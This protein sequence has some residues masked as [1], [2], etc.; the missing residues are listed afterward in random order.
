M[1]PR[2][3]PLWWPRH[4]PNLLLT[5]VPRRSSR[6]A[7][8]RSLQTFPD[9]PLLALWTRARHLGSIARLR[10][11]PDHVT[12][13]LAARWADAFEPL[14]PELYWTDGA[15]DALDRAAPY[16]SLLRGGTAVSI[17]PATDHAAAWLAQVRERR[18]A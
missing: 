7:I 3:P 1:L 11:L 8:G 17:A 14:I 15:T 12:A 5:P 10:A 2:P 18:I 4:E 13:P 9:F 16:L 6:Q